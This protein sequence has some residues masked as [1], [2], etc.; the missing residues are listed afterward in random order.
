MYP[1]FYATSST[2][3]LSSISPVL[4]DSNKPKNKNDIAKLI[5]KSNNIT[6]FL[7]IERVED[8]R[9]AASRCQKFIQKDSDT[10]LI[11]LKTKK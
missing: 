1:S 11:L 7:F 8:S 3:N 10:T 6:D 4:S 9:L 2:D 5:Q